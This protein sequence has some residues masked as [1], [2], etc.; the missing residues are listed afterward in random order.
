[1]GGPEDGWKDVQWGKDV[2]D[3]L[4]KNHQNFWLQ[5]PPGDRQRRFVAERGH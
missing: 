3:W 4:V 5:S 2:V 1:M